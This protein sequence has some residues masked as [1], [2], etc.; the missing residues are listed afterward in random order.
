MVQEGVANHLS[1]PGF[2]GSNARVAAVR[3]RG[4]A[5]HLSPAPANVCRPRV[6]PAFVP[7]RRLVELLDAGEGR[8]V[9]LVSA[10]AGW[11]K[12]LLVA[13]WAAATAVHEPV[14]WLSLDAE[15]NDPA[16]FWSHVVAALRHAGAI[17][18]IKD[19]PDLGYGSSMNQAFIGR[20]TNGLARLPQRVTLVLD[21]LD[22]IHEPRVVKD[23]AVL[24]RALP[25]QMRLVLVARNDPLLPLYRLRTEGQLT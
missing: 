25:E 21:D 15:D 5:A 23:L 19:F 6:P 10:G 13:S 11:G 3:R 16:V 17:Q 7:R 22:E 1:S 9:T 2:V 8:P 20:L 14:G 24:L 12:T 4:S 18:D